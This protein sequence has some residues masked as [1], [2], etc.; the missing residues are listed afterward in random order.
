MRLLEGGLVGT[1]RAVGVGVV[2]AV[3][4]G[5]MVLRGWRGAGVEWLKWMKV[6][7]SSD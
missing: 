1:G 7:R 3:G 5:C 6:L 4:L 2:D